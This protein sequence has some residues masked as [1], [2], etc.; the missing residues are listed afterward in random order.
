MSK[1]RVTL[2]EAGSATGAARPWDG[3]RG[4]FTAVGSFAGAT[5]SL[6]VLGPD[7]ATWIP[8]GP[9]VRLVTAGVGNFE[10]PAGSIRAA[11]SGGSP[12][13]LTAIAVGMA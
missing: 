5:V 2:I 8:V 13:G 11:V 10:L 1:Q 7:G 9:D 3:G 4:Q 12:S 6:E